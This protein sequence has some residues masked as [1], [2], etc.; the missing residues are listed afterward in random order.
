MD[1]FRMPRYSTDEE[2]DFEPLPVIKFLP[3]NNGPGCARCHSLLKTKAVW[4]LEVKIGDLRDELAATG[5][6]KCP[7]CRLLWDG[8]YAV[9]GLD[10][11]AYQWLQVNERGPDVSMGPLSVTLCP[12]WYDGTNEPPRLRDGPSKG[13]V[14]RVEVQYY[15]PWDVEA[16][17]PWVAVGKGYHIATE[18]LAD[19]CV[20]LARTWLRDCTAGSGKHTKSGCL[21]SRTTPL[22]KRVIDVENNKL[23]LPSP[24]EKDRYVALSHCWGGSTP[25]RTTRGTLA[26]HLK[27]LPSLLPAT[28]RDA[29]AV[30]KMLGVRFLWIDSLCII[31]DDKDDWRSEAAHMATIYESALV[32]ISADAASCSTDGFLAASTRQ[33]K[34][35]AEVPYSFTGATG[36]GVEGVVCVRERGKLGLL[37][38]YHGLAGVRSQ[39]ETEY[40]WADEPEAPRSI[41]STRGWVFQER[42]LSPRTLHFSEFEMAWEC[43]SICTCE[44]SVT[45]HRPYVYESLLKGL[46]VNDDDQEYFRDLWRVEVVQEYSRLALTFPQDRLIAL[47]GLATAVGR[48]R[49]EDQYIAGLW[50]SSLGEDLLWAVQPIKASARLSSRPAASWSWGS[51]TGAVAYGRS[52]RHDR[53]RRRLSESFQV[54]R[55]AVRSN[56]EDRFSDPLM[57]S[58][59]KVTGQV[60]RGKLAGVAEQNKTWFVP[61]GWTPTSTY[62]G[63]LP[64]FSQPAPSPGPFLV[65]WDV[66]TRET[67]R[68]D[69]RP[70]RD[71]QVLFLM[72]AEQLGGPCGLLL[73][74][75]DSGSRPSSRCTCSRVGFVYS[76]EDSSP[77][78][79]R[80]GSIPDLAEEER[81]DRAQ[82]GLMWKR[83]DKLSVK[84]RLSIE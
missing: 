84:M 65:A 34:P 47:A 3:N 28:F 44:C 59:L 61:D 18:G 26:A 71:R 6:I 58:S 54:Y 25:V 51:V 17:S 5:R 7:A 77:V 57:G 1:R 12:G 66:M 52:S 35:H 30:T 20:E 45:S 75:K 21:A 63:S 46:L 43:R 10:I 73:E 62:T 55:V 19:S 16:R 4:R 76:G 69:L 11:Y 33:T 39:K 37:L 22:P 32:T 2:D 60:L 14:L 81:Q 36:H 74:E 27:A 82:M 24:N 29:I 40:S 70:Y 64:G 23:Y 15:T 50:R 80:R 31:Q 83:W 56:G 49:P 68:D 8:A 72:V 67:S 79:R 53:G 9:V 13:K 42:I 48:L 38:P 41:L 78:P